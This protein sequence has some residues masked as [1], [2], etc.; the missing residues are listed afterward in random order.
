MYTEK[1]SQSLCVKVTI[2][3]IIQGPITMIPV[4]MAITL[5]TK[6]RVCSCMD[7]TVWKIDTVSPTDSD[8]SNSG[9]AVV[10]TTY[11]VLLIM[12]ETIFIVITGPP[13]YDV[14]NAVLIKCLDQ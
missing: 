11:S 6:V 4:N 5:G 10:M 3:F 7:V 13:F 1:S 8:I 12:S 2:L 14:F 9:A